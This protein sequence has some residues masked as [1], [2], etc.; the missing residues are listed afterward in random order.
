MLTAAERNW[1]ATKP[2]RIVWKEERRMVWAGDDLTLAR[3]KLRELRK[4]HP[5]QTFEKHGF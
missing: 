4:G 2:Y 5:K 1:L 3:R